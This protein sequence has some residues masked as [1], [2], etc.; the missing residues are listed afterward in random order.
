MTTVTQSPEPLAY[1][2]ADACKVS[3][4]GKTNLYKLIANGKLEARKV[5]K[6]TL[7]PA[8]SLRALIEPGA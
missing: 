8:A 4:I 7:I 5:G 2:V 3:S 6:R 1:S